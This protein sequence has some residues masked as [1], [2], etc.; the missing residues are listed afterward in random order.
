MF[1]PSGDFRLI[2]YYRLNDNNEIEECTPSQAEE[3]IHSE[4]KIVRQEYVGE[5]FVS[6]V[7]LTIDHNFLRYGD[8]I[9]FET[10]IFGNNSGLES[11]CA[12]YRTYQEALRGH[13]EVVEK[14]KQGLPL[15]GND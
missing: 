3:F 1:F 10:M 2:K 14:L 7:M 13:N 12:R 9:L 5:K 4:R 8:P 11:Y 15:N 6:T